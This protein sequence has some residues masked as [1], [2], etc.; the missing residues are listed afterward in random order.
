MRTITRLTV[1][2]SVRRLSSFPRY[3]TKNEMN[4]NHKLC[5]PV[6]PVTKVIERIKEQGEYYGVTTSV[7]SYTGLERFLGRVYGCTGL[8]I[9]ATLGLAQGLSHYGL[10][11]EYPVHCFGAGIVM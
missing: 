9:A 2:P 11:L 3:V 6:Q 7:K 5:I 10:A 1:R 8:S 4:K